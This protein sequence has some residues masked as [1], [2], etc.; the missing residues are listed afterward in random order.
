MSLK[1]PSA[2]NNLTNLDGQGWLTNEGMRNRTGS[3][4]SRSVADEHHHDS[5]P[6][7]TGGHG[8]RTKLYFLLWFAVTFMGCNA[9]P[10]VTDPA[11][12]TT[13]TPVERLLV[14]MQNEDW[15]LANQ[16]AQE[17]LIISPE[18]PDLLTYEAKTAAFCDRRS[19]AAQLLVEAAR[20]AEY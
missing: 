4:P 9:E 5:R 7:N 8:Y 3:Q 19:E 10:E 2:A 13:A 1:T 11:P 18:D 16:Y 14:A 6:T 15:E 17:A 12:K 20:Y